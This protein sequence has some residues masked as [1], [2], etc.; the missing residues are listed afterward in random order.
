MRIKSFVRSYVRGFVGEWK[1]RLIACLFLRRGF[2]SFH[3]MTLPDGG[4]GTTQIDHIF[5]S[6]TGV[7]VVETKCFSGKITGQSSHPTWVQ[8]LGSRK[9]Q[10]QNPIH[11]NYKHIKVVE[12]LC[13]IPPAHLHSLVVFSGSAT[14]PDGLPS[15][16]FGMSNFASWIRSHH[17]QVFTQEQVDS[18]AATL[19]SRV[20]PRGLGTWLAH[21]MHLRA[22]FAA[23]R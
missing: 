22:R 18:I 4:G 14:F 16:V 8:W 5:V 7:F 21:V 10:F 15:G 3:D 9:F 2:V 17:A 20:L 19:G 1:V 11:Q 23:K 6:R 13:A 12:A